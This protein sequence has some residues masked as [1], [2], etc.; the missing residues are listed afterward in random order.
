M[1]LAFLA[2]Q[3]TEF[4]IGV[5]REI[6]EHGES[7]AARVAAANSLL[8]RAHGKPAQSVEVLHADLTKVEYPTEEEIIAEIKRRNLPQVLELIAP[9]VVTEPKV[10]IEPG[11]HE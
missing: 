3:H 9:K 5:L 11:K 2:R 6:A 10:V 1:S 4:A 8:D 7:E